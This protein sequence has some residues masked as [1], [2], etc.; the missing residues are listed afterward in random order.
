MLGVA[1]AVLLICSARSFAQ[2]GYNDDRVMIQGFIRESS[3]DGVDVD[4]E[5]Q[6]VTAHNKGKW[7]KLVADHAKELAD[8]EFDLIWLPPPSDCADDPGYIPRRLYVFDNNYGSADD[9]KQCLKA[10]LKAGVE[11]VA[12]VVI[13]HRAGTTG[14]ADFTEP[15]WPSTFICS[16]D[17]FWDQPAGSLNAVD[18][19]VKAANQRGNADFTFSDYNSVNYARDL[20]HSNADFRKAVKEYLQKLQGLGYRGWRYDLAK[21]YDANRIAEYDFGSDPT[22]A[23]G[24]YMDNRPNLVSSWIDGTK[25]QGQP[26]PAKRACSAFDFPHAVAARQIPRRRAVRP[27]PL[28]QLQGQRRRRADRV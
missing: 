27:A 5:G 21:G 23:V 28:D 14:W 2:G 10:L 17:E 6:K 8:A 15:T 22:F 19:Q 13:N 26:D 24:E 20:D 12:D 16:D 4:V 1:L 25:L 7:Y 3:I 9:Q 18:Q 11:P